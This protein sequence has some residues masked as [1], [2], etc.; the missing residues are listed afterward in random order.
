M[1]MWLRMS[2]LHTGMITRLDLSQNHF[3]RSLH[4]PHILSVLGAV[5][6]PFTIVLITNL[7]QGKNLHALVF[8]SESA[9]M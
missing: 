9:V 3:Y 2:Y 5:S 4:H 7:V 6:R 8:N 1:K